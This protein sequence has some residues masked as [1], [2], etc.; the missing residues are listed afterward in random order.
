MADDE[1]ERMGLMDAILDQAMRAGVDWPE[2]LLLAIMLNELTII[3]LR[4]YYKTSRHLE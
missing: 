2:S 3:E 1:R 4:L